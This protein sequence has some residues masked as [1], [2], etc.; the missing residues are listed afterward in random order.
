[1]TGDV[2]FFGVELTWVRSCLTGRT[3]SIASPKGTAERDVT[4]R[5]R[6]A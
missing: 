3:R 1:M 2:P 6:T 5:L 4:P